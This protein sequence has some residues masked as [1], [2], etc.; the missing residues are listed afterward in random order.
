MRAGRQ[1][2]VLE[3]LSLVPTL[4]SRVS[5]SNDRRAVLLRSLPLRWPG[6]LVASHLSP[7]SLQLETICSFIPHRRLARRLLLPI[8][9]ASRGWR[10][11]GKGSSTSTRT[12]RLNKGPASRLSPVPSYG[13]LGRVSELPW[14]QA[15]GFRLEGFDGQNPVLVSMDPLLDFGGFLPA[16]QQEGP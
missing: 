8:G 10:P 7:H 1:Q 4:R 16:M 2:L 3:V 5:A 9:R 11:F 15:E 13:S 12:P 14:L 6:L